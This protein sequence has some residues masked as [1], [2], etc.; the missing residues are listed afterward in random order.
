MDRRYTLWAGDFLALEG[1]IWQKQ[2]VGISLYPGDILLQLARRTA[3]VEKV[4]A[5]D[6]VVM[7]TSLSLHFDKK[8]KRGKS[9]DAMI[10]WTH[11]KS[12]GDLNVFSF[13]FPFVLHF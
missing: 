12:W 1:D 3:C 8:A 13:Y 11:N 9:A 2:A 6:V 7:S 4:N 5:W 10:W